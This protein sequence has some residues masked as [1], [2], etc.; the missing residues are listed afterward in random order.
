MS[1]THKHNPDAMMS[2]G[3]SHNL[4]MD[5][6]KV[7]ARAKRDADERHEARNRAEPEKILPE[8]K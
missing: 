2:R 4:R 3:M 8:K 7:L 1:K 5:V 6:G